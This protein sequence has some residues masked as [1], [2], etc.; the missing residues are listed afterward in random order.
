MK[1]LSYPFAV[2][3]Q[4]FMQKKFLSFSFHVAWEMQISWPHPNTIYEQLR[5][6]IFFALKS[7]EKEVSF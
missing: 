6:N 7:L 1:T 4:D 5:F 3:Y 2:V